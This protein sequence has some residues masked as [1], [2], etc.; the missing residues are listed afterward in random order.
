[1]HSG[2][3]SKQQ[4]LPNWQIFISTLHFY[5]I[6]TF[7]KTANMEPLQNFLTPYLC[8]LCAF[9]DLRKRSVLSFSRKNMTR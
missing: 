6:P 2:D 7:A 5:C 1:M 9:A 3:K 8:L 4:S